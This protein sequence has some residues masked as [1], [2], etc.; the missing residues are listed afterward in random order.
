MQRVAAKIAAPR[1]A[2][3]LA[4]ELIIIIAMKDTNEMAR[5]YHSGQLPYYV[6]RTAKNIYNSN[7][8]AFQKLYRHNETNTEI[9]ANENISEIEY[10]YF[11]D[12]ICEKLLAEMDN[13]AKDN[14][15]PYAKKLFLMFVELGNKKEIER[16]TKI[17]Y[18]SICATIYECQLKLKYVYKFYYLRHNGGH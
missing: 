1:Y 13:W 4:H 5:L 8:S 15:F 2:D 3:D 11:I 18:R 14:G 17:P 7:N 12:F 9:D 16:R 6:A 10:D